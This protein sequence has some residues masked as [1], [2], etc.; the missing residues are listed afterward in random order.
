MGK[1]ADRPLLDFLGHF[2]V[3]GRPLSPFELAS[4]FDFNLLIRR[5]LF[6][7]ELGRDHDIARV[8]PPASPP[9]RFEQVSSVAGRVGGILL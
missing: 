8:G 2:V 4:L 9:P 3:A 5:I 6:F 7:V 1:A